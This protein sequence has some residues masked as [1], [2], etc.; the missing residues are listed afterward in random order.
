MN[1]IKKSFVLLA[2]LFLFACPAAKAQVDTMQVPMGDFEQ[3][4]DHPADS[5]S[6]LFFSLPIDY[7]Y[8]LPNGWSVPFYEIDETVN[9]SGLNLNIQ[10]NVAMGI[11]YADTVNAPVGHGAL[12]TQSFMMEDILTPTAYSLAG[13]LLDSTLTASVL[14]TIALTGNVNVANLLPLLESLMGA[15]DMSWMLGMLDSVDINDYITGGFPL[16]GMDP[17]KLIGYYKYIYPQT[18]PVRDNG[19]V[20]AIGTRY[21]TTEHRRMLVGAGSKLLYQ[22]YDTVNYE[23]FEM[24][25]TSLSSYY[26]SGYDFYDADSMVVMVVSSANEKNRLRGSRLFV[27]DLRLVRRGSECGRI[28]DLREV[29]HSYSVAQIAW[30]NTASPD[31]W[32]VEYGETGFGLGRGTN[33]T[34]HDS[35]ATFPELTPGLTYDIYVRGICGDTSYTDWVYMT[36]STDPLPQSIDM[37]AEDQVQVYPN[38]AKDHV[39]VECGTAEVKTVRVYDMQG[40]LLQELSHSGSKYTVDLPKSGMYY[41]EVVTD[42]GIAYRKVVGC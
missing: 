29:M 41:L 34:V 27:D 17:S 13:S 5:A 42:N 24:D 12:V 21:D 16:N 11:T 36:L 30:G 10:A 39:T 33:I 31:S 18:S 35:T 37:T 20:I 22:L 26:P 28:V 8:S 4:V 25:Y 40:R 6:V 3:W 9:Y 1:N 7:G 23:P 14:P 2:A 15:D 38:P 19:A 32:E